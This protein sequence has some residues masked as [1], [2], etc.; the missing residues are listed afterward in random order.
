[1][2][3]PIPIP[4][5]AV[6]L[7]GGLLL[8][9]GLLVGVSTADVVVDGFD[10][11]AIQ[12]AIDIAGIGGTVIFPAGTYDITSVIRPKSNQTLLSQ[13]ATLRRS[14]PILTTLTQPAVAG[15][16]KLVVN[17][18]S[19]YAIGMYVTPIQPGGGYNQIEEKKHYVTAISGQE[20]TL[21]RALERNYSLGD[22]VS[23]YFDMLDPNRTPVTIEGFTFD[24]NRDAQVLSAWT[25]NHAIYAH[26]G[27]VARNNLFVDL[28]G[29][30]IGANGGN[31]LIEG[32]TFYRTDT[33][34]IHLSN[35]F[36]ED[37]DVIIRD[38]L[39]IETNAKFVAARH[40]E[41]AITISKRNKHIRVLDNFGSDLPVPLIGS[42]HVDMHDWTIENNTIW[43]ANG[44]FQGKENG[45][46][47]AP[48][49]R[50]VAVIDNKVFDSGTSVMNVLLPVEGM[51]VVGNYF[52][53]SN[54]QL[55]D[56]TGS[57]TGN[58]IRT[59][60]VDPLIIINGDVNVS[61]NILDSDYCGLHYLPGDA[62]LDG[63]VDVADF[64]IWNSHRFMTPVTWGQ[65]DF[66]GDR[67][68]DISDFNVW[69]ANKFSVL[70]A[71]V[72]EPSAAVA[73]SWGLILLVIQRRRCRR[74]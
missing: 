48:P 27:L 36:V 40:S 23:N 60:G 74:R 19:Q 42:F 24:G 2:R 16:T 26:E 33:S 20:L 72:P 31:S 58:T 15:S 59:C 22:T 41:G 9:G 37:D 8:S 57:V 32:N 14:D 73:A 1:M 68:V 18:T 63:A 34:G 43:N 44:L 5:Y 25:R 54:L 13:A 21:S 52:G 64:N 46:V 10:T 56:V 66:N 7:L 51:S 61:D 65:G 50:D 17:D 39:F 4:L 45:V 12:A 35:D 6:L 69:N 55:V 38:N 3:K 47:T 70:P 49:L 71:L 53:G 11:A 62:N 28:P 29:D 30:G 67:V